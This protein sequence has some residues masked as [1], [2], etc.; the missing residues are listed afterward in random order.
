MKKGGTIALVAA[1]AAAL[2]VVLFVTTIGTDP[3][4]P[5]I[6][7]G[8]SSSAAGGV[9]A[10][11]FAKPMKT[12]AGQVTSPFGARWGTQHNGMDIAGPIGTPIY[13][14]ADGIVTQAGPASGFGNW[15]VLDH[16]IDGQL[17]ST[18]YGHMFA[19]GVLVKVG[20]RVTAGQHIANEGNDGQSTGAHLHF[21]YLSLIH[22]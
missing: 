7:R 20:D 11:S 5:C 12:S 4:D 14:Y 22:I 9:P 10:G 13:A 18:V 21:E 19:D 15:I 3:D 1:L 17:V 16:N 8:G 6:P 2:F